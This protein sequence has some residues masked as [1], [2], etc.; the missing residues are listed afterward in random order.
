MNEL[1]EID[2]SFDGALREISHL[3]D[4]IK[5]L[6]SDNKFLTELLNEAVRERESLRRQVDALGN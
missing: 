2:R 5:Q 4:R 3:C 6:E 1:P